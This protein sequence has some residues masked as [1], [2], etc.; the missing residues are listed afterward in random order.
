MRDVGRIEV[1]GV[2]PGGD[3]G[4]VLLAAALRRAEVS[5]STTSPCFEGQV[6]HAVALV[7]L[8]PDGD[9]EALRQ[10]IGDRHADAVQ[11]ARERVGAARTLVELAARVQAG[12]HDFDGRDAFFRVD[13]DRDA[14]A[15]VFDRDRAV[16]VHRHGDVLA[17]AAQRL[18]GGVVDHFLDDVQRV[19]GAGVHARTLLD[20]FQSLEDPDG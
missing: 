3:A 14:A 5:G 20:G 2:R 17:V 18:V 19:F 8:A 10:R 12:E 7:V 4:A 15:V 11:A 6:V 13:A 1:F 9:L 16:G